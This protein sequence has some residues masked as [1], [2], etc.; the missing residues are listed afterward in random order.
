ML[1][2]LSIFTQ[3]YLWLKLKRSGV[4]KAITNIFLLLIFF[5]LIIGYVAGY[6]Y[7]HAEVN[8][9]P[10]RW[11]EI[12]R[13]L[14]MTWT[15]ITILSFFAVVAVSII[16]AKLRYAVVLTVIATL[17]CMGE[18]YYV[19]P[20]YVT[21]HTDKL[22][23][24]IE[25]LRVVYLTD[26]HIGGLSTHWHFSRVMKIVEDSHP[27]ILA[28]CGDIIDGVMSYRGRELAMLADAAKNAKY[29]AYAVNGNHEYYWLLDEDVE[30]I[31]RDCGVNMLIDERAETAGITIIGV[32]D[33]I[34]GGWLKPFL[35]PDDKNKFVLVLKHRP[36]L[37]FDAEGNFD[38]Q[39][40]GHTH[41]GQ[42]WP[43]G[44]FKDRV[45]DSVQGLSRKAGGYVYVSNG[46]GFNGAMMRLFVP[47]EVT[48]I[49]IVG[50]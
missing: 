18:A 14:F 34:E 6:D 45:A 1:W 44:Y 47:P 23:P 43:L 30:Q 39:I 24:D 40:S 32:D 21:I 35:K 31:I 41:G 15:I 10:G 50:E 37:P 16:G 26:A 12:L 2:Q 9:F 27:D 11:C 22:P 38:L 25:K 28:L 17:Y 42:F 3:L 7:G 48:V 46:S 8:I 19:T 5:W 29:G 36:G 13:A 4:S 20:R 33:R 49:D